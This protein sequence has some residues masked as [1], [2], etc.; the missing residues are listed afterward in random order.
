VVKLEL[1]KGVNKMAGDKKKSKYLTPEH[2]APT[3]EE[4]AFP[5][6]RLFKTN[7]N[8]ARGI[9]KD[10]NSAVKKGFDGTVDDYYNMSHRGGTKKYNPDK[11]ENF[12]TGRQLKANKQKKIVKKASGGVI[13][14]RNYLKGR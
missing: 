11:K 13:L 8:T 10:Y 6:D 9:T 3:A 4:V 7:P 5:M 2:E 12:S 14:D 1:N